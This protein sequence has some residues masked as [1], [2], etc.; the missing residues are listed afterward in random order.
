MHKFVI[1]D[2]LLIYFI[3]YTHILI[4]NII[5]IDTFIVRDWAICP[6]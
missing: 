5:T 1:V 2:P 4:I 6:L 3:K